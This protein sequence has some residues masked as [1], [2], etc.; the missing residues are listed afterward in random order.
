MVSTF[1]LTAPAGEDRKIGWAGVYEL[2][3]VKSIR[4]PFTVLFLAVT[5][6]LLSSSDPEFIGAGDSVT[7][8][9]FVK[10]S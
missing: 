10:G 4:L 6:G 2:D 5:T 7:C 3:T 8:Y 1:H 9:D